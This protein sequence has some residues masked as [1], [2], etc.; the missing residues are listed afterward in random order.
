MK[1]VFEVSGLGFSYPAKQALKDVSLTV[2]EGER[3]AVLGPNGSGKSTL[4]K[5]LSAV[6]KPDV[7]EVRLLGKNLHSYDRRALSRKLA[8]VPQETHVTFPYTVAQVVLMG[9]ASRLAP[10]ALEGQN[11]LEIARASL[12][13]TGTLNLADR[14][15]HELSSGEKQRVILARAL[16]QEATILVLDEPTTFLDIRHQIEIH[17]LISEL[18]DRQGWT[19]IS[20]LHDL[21][22]A[23]LYFP[24]LV[25]LQDGSVHCSGSPEQVLTEETIERVYGARVQVVRNGIRASPQI[26]PGVKRRG[27]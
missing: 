17:E 18:S 10:F 14:Y 26:L 8:V 16:A 11:D 2:A 23:S 15:L 22:L 20:A 12:K 27:R 24:K 6:L 1:P 25:L 19:V 7:G 4:L 3:V 13:S 5:I 9:R 21:N